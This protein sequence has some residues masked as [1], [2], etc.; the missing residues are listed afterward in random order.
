MSEPSSEESFVPAV[1]LRQR[2]RKAGHAGI[3]AAAALH[4]TATGNPR[5]RFPYMAPGSERPVSQR[6]VHRGHQGD[7]RRVWPASAVSRRCRP[8]SGR[9]A[10]PC[11]STTALTK[12][13]GRFL[14][15]DLAPSLPTFRD[16]VRV[17]DHNACY[18]G[19]IR[20]PRAVARVFLTLLRSHSPHELSDRR[21][22]PVGWAEFRC[23]FSKNDS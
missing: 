6:R 16:P 18:P 12:A 1:V 7:G 19:I 23:R 9:A 2:K 22:Y 8:V 4:R 3:G 15:R 13:K 21:P 20:H 17:P 5:Y 10:F 14:S 11:A